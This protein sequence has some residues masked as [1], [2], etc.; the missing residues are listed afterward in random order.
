MKKF[1]SLL[2]LLCLILVGCGSKPV[3]TTAAPTEAP[4]AA[5]TE[6]PT[7]APTEA[8]TEAPTEPPVP[9]D[10]LT[11]EPLE[12]P[13]ETR[14]FAVT[15]NNVPVAMPMYGVSEADLFFEMY[16]NSHTTRG[17]AFFSDISQVPA[18]GSVR[19]LRY[20]FTDLCQIYDAVPIYASGDKR[21]V[22]DFNASGLQG[23]NTGAYSGDYKFIDW[24]RKN[25]G[26]PQEHCLFVRGAESV[27]T[28]EA[29]GIRIT[30]QEDW[31]YGLDFT[32]EPLT[33]G[34]KA[35]LVNIN[36]THNGVTKR[37]VMQY[38]ASAGRYQFI[39]YD[40][41]MYDA[42]LEKNIYF[43]NVIVMFCNVYDEDVYHIA[44]LTGGG[45]GYFAWGGRIIPICWSRE[46]EADPISFTHTDGTPLEL[47]VG[48]SYIALAPLTSTVTYE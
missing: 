47:G 4:T 18:I 5:V 7:E 26:K 21:V 25:S 1:F 39:Q 45:E 11:G 14:V 32:E 44:E 34:E 16:I 40:Q 24:E 2:L 41:A 13:Q 9:T 20:N 3:E 6:A 17:L 10:P 29:A 42:F 27:A 23:L 35:A 15:I 43:D 31:D 28:A 30:R 12:A 48:N 36:L 22:A 19:S 33:E 38:D 8:H 37:T 46:T